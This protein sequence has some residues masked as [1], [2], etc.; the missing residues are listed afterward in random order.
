MHTHTPLT[1]PR[2]AADCNVGPQLA[3]CCLMHTQS[4]A[5]QTAF[6][7]PVWIMMQWVRQART[8]SWAKYKSEEWCWGWWGS[9]ESVLP[10]LLNQLRIGQVGGSSP[11]PPWTLK[12]QPR[13]DSVRGL[14]RCISCK[15]LSNRL[16]SICAH[17]L[18]EVSISRLFS[19]IP[20]CQCVTHPEKVLLTDGQW[21]SLQPGRSMSATPF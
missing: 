6:Q 14:W 10:A 21:C 7:I 9:W 12:S 15:I 2:W 17:R 16:F 20:T 11:F 3:N 5:F 18:A 8:S 13:Q 19:A 1:C 4:Q